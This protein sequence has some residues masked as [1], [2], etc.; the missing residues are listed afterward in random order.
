M[1]NFLPALLFLLNVQL[2]AQIGVNIGLPERG[3]TYID[4]ARENYRWVNLNTG[5]AINFSEVD[6]AGWP[7]VDA[8]YVVD[9][10][11]VAE[12]VGDIDD[13][14]VYRLDVS[15]TWTCSFNG[16]GEVA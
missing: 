9:F 7:T 5:S 1:K 6:E 4:L 11:P 8:Q 12:W 13:P 15:G 16:E 2:A 10:R 14:E 3:G